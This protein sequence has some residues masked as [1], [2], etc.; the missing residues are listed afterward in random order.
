MRDSVPGRDLGRHR[1]RRAPLLRRRPA[2]RASTPVLQRL[3][4]PYRVDR[5]ARRAAATTPPRTSTPRPASSRPPRTWRASTPP[6]TTTTLLRGDL[7]S[8]AWSNVTTSSGAP[9]PSGP[10]L[11]RADLQRRAP[12]VAL[13]R[14]PAA[15]RRRC[16]SRCRGATSRSS[17]SPTA[18][19]S[20]RRRSPRAMSPPRSSP[21]CSCE[22][23]SAEARPRAASRATRLLIAALLAVAGRAGAGAGRHLRLA[24]PRREVQ[25][26]HQRTRLR[27]TAPR[28]TKLTLGVSGVVVSDKGL[29]VEVELGY[30]PRFFER[31]HRQSRDPQRRDDAV[32]QRRA[33]AADQHHARVAAALRRRR[34]RLDPRLGQRQHRLQRGQQRL[35][36]PGARRR[37]D[38]LRHRHRP[39]CASTCAT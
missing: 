1:H 10:R 13:R 35:P 27:A 36:R 8:V 6:S 20:A 37:R 9:L 39:A 18:T 32:R 34:P 5:A 24:L 12:G 26:R 14:H 17:C 2:R 7:L 15:R 11:V 4:M 29:G 25:G 30:N 31:R 3:A 23:S 19:A 38:R 28:D 33:G 16:S 21:S 22:S